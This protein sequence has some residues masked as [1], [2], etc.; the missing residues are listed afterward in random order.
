MNTEALQELCQAHGFLLEMH[1]I[2]ADSKEAYFAIL[3]PRLAEALDLDSR[4]S[5]IDLLRKKL[6]QLC[7]LIEYVTIQIG[8]D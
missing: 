7:P 3:V 4:K 2:P 1:R 8:S 5:E 6:I